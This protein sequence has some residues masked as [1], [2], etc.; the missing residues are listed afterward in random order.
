M[1]SDTVFGATA[2]FL[3]KSAFKPNTVKTYQQGQDS[4]YRFCETFQLTALPA[5]EITLIYFVCYLF[6]KKLKGSTIRVYLA[7][8]RNLHILKGFPS[9]LGGDR[10]ALALKGT[11]VLSPPLPGG[12]RSLTPY[13]SKCSPYVKGVLTNYYLKR[14]CHW[15]SLVACAQDEE[16]APTGEPE[17]PIPPTA[18]ATESPPEEGMPTAVPEEEPIEA[19]AE[20]AASE[21][22]PIYLAIIWH[23]H[24]PV[25]FKDTQSNVYQRPWVRMHAAKDY[26]DMVTF[27][28]TF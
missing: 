27:L 9:P 24:Q 8:V 6:D 7:G 13:W 22:G 21:V 12:S 28:A 16:P 5:S 17:V 14:P 1:F 19:P 3:I 23:Q 10:L 26:V 20:E 15:P 25:Y 18:G 11:L 2:E 4:F